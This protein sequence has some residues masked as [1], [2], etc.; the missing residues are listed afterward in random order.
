M[1]KR[2]HEHPISV[3][4]LMFFFYNLPKALQFVVKNLVGLLASKRLAMSMDCLKEYR[5]DD[6]DKV[7]NDKIKFELYMAKRI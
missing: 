2:T 5:S 6:I 1:F 4:G 3:Y 7:L